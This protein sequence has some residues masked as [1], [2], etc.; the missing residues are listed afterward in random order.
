MATPQWPAV[1]PGRGKE[2]PAPGKGPAVAGAGGAPTGAG[3]VPGGGDHRDLGIDAGQ[4]T[5]ALEAE[6]AVPAGAVLDPD[7]PLAPLR[8]DVSRALLQ[9][10]RARRRQLGRE[11][12]DLRLGEIRDAAGVIEVEVCGEDVADI[13]R[14]MAER[15]DL[16]D[17]R[18]ALLADRGGHRA[19][20]PA[21]AVRVGAVTEAESR[22][23]QDQ[24][25]V[26]LDQQAVGYD[27]RRL[28]QPALAGEQTGASRAHRSAVE[29]RDLDWRSLCHCRLDY[30]DNPTNERTARPCSAGPRDHRQQPL[31]GARDGQRERPA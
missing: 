6:P 20:W 3:G 13:G 27:L 21:E 19:E 4:R 16:P 18:L 25:P 23:D 30:P 14:V 9:G 10:W 11:D 17:R 1:C 31:H 7:R 29:V 8:A 15:L 24:L 5:D 22:V 12:V 2:G 28:Q 26:G